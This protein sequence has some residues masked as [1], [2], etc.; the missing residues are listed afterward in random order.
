MTRTYITTALKPV[1]RTSVR[2]DTINAIMVDGLMDCGYRLYK[3]DA[4]RL[5]C[6]RPADRWGYEVNI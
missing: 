1:S 6:K 5:I 2:L 3:T 4:G